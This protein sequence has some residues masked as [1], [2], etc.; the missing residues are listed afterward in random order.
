M[1]CFD[2]FCIICGNTCHDVGKSSYTKWLREC[3]VLT[4]FGDVVHGCEETA[5]NTV[6]RD[7]KGN[8]YDVDDPSNG[9]LRGHCIF[10]HTDCWKFVEKTCKI[11]L[12]IHHLPVRKIEL[13]GDK[14]I[15]EIK[16]GEIEKYWGQDFDFDLMEKDNKAYIAYS[17]LRDKRSAARVKKIL[18]QLKLKNDPNRQGPLVSATFYKRNVVKMGSNGFFW[19][20]VQGKW[21]EIPDKVCTLT[22]ASKDYKGDLLFRKRLRRIPHV[23]M[24]STVPVFIKYQEV[25]KKTLKTTFVCTEPYLKRLKKTFAEV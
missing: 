2:I 16:Y 25:V 7:P 24:C 22:I 14:I 10:L 3:T 8:E 11:K 4:T 5:C 1:G 18:P 13:L 6:F 12:T 20:V 19:K 23:G 15:P 21:K 17:P 9:R